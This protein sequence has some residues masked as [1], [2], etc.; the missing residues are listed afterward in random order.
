MAASSKTCVSAGRLVTCGQS[1]ENQR[2]GFCSG[3]LNQNNF[4]GGIQFSLEF[5]LG[6][7]LN[8]VRFSGMAIVLGTLSRYYC[9]AR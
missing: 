4:F 7:G 9:R 6:L 8:I 3:C 5:D 1:G 2:S